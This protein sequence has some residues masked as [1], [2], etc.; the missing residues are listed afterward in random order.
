[1]RKRKVGE[2]LG[3]EMRC[4]AY[5][6]DGKVI[7][8]GDKDGRVRLFDGHT[9]EPGA[10][11]DD[12]VEPVWQVAFAPDGKTLVSIS[13]DKTAKLWDVPAGKLRRTLK[14]NQGRIWAVAFS[15]DGKWLA[16]GGNFEQE[17]GKWRA[18]VILWDARS[19]EMKQA[20]PGVDAQRFMP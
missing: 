20:L 15:P 9:G 4:L 7:A 8:G 12:H 6:P 14:G 13:D 5:S 1:E 11:L 19:G 2:D 3:K 10:V 17:Q 16:T 18:E